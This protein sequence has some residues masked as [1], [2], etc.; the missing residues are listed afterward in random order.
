MKKEFVVASALLIFTALNAFSDDP[1][2]KLAVYESSITV[3]GDRIPLEE[4]QATLTPAPIIVITR[5]DIESSGAATI[6]QLLSDIPG[7]AAHDITGNPVERTIDLRG[8]P[9]GTS[10]SVF[11]DGVR[12]NNIEDNSVRWDV[13]PLSQIERIEIYSGALA[14]LYGGGAIGGV[15]NIVTKKGAG[16]PRIDLTAGL[17][18]FGGVTERLSFSGSLGNWD[19]MS[20]FGIDR[21]EGYRENDGHRLDDGIVRA[22]YNFGEGHSLSFLAK[23]EGGSIS[24]P[25]ALTD[26]E[27]N[28]DRRQSPY[29]LYDGTRGRHRLF[30]VTYNRTFGEGLNLAVEGFSRNHDRDTLTTGRYMTGFLTAGEEDL[31]G[32]IFQLD[33]R[34]PFGKG[35]FEW[36][37]S[38]ESADGSYDASGWYT[39]FY[40]NKQMAAT[41]TS[42]GQDTAG[43]Y[44]RLGYTLSRFRMDAGYRVDEA[45]YDY[46]DLLFPSNNEKR[47][48]REGTTR[49]SAS[50]LRSESESFFLAFSEGYRIPGVIEL[51]AYPGFY[52]NP[53]LEPT[54]VNDFEAG[55]K[56]FGDKL[57]ANI[58]LYKMFLREETVF[59]LTDPAHFIGQNMNIGKSE[60]EGV[61]GSISLFLPKNLD[62]S[63]DASLRNCEATAGPYDGMAVPMVPERTFSLGLDWKGGMFG[64]GGRLAYVGPQYL[65]NDLTNDREKL[66]SYYSASLSASYKNGPVTVEL[67]VDNLFDREY[68][69][70][71]I[72]N[73][74]T[75][76]FS[77]SRPFG[78]RLLVTYSW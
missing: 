22:T 24:T 4:R 34:K 62:L 51:F 10:V 48:F 44:L 26:E 1:S 9:E 11:L 47:T 21:S 71:G 23:Y 6:Q 12:L 28:D 57:K 33:G 53:D 25:G 69:T 27:L 32:G 52:S 73:G 5:D 41:R 74:F 60:R 15:V 64:A 58:T 46:K 40:G 49:F 45:K 66:S 31:A 61:E 38:G 29:N 39:D 13:V 35:V 50:F 72:T 70:R 37:F 2:R 77:P 20:A 42:T 8:F 3:Y 18:S 59:V 43:G 75:D 56:Y 67:Q 78:A 17:G 76:Y 63:L 14:P 36:A 30:A 68:S 16:L 7:A 65:S 54:R 19:L 55:Y